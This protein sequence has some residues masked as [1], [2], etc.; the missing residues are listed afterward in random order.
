MYSFSLY[1]SLR[2][3]YNIWVDKLP[4]FKCTLYSFVVI[5][6]TCP[7]KILFFTLIIL[8]HFKNIFTTMLVDY[9]LRTLIYYIHLY[10]KK[11]HVILL[12]WLPL[13]NNKKVYLIKIIICITNYTILQRY[14]YT[15]QEK[16]FDFVIYTWIDALL[17]GKLN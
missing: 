1:F 16:I 13:P 11:F 9:L 8:L 10:I 3:K 15:S 17:L 7:T 2:K 6:V 5:I 14:G 4:C 12:Y